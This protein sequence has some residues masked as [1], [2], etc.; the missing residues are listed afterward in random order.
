MLQYA[1]YVE[2][3]SIS[4]KHRVKETIK[5]LVGP[6]NSNI[7]FEQWYFIRRWN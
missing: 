3:M 2:K 7:E 4:M 6:A 5:K 1:K